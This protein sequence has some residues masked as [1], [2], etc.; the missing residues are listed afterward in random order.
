MATDAADA[1][2]AAI[3]AELNAGQWTQALTAAHEHM[4]NKQAD[5]LD[6]LHVSVV[7][8]DE[9]SEAEDRA[10]GVGLFEIDLIFQKQLGLETEDAGHATAQTG[11]DPDVAALLNLIAAV[12]L[13][14]PFGHRPTVAGL[15]PIQVARRHRPRVHPDLL[16]N[17]RLFLSVLT[18]TY[19]T[20]L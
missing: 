19:R 4:P 11:D 8:P 14:M 5:E 20:R 1:I 3:A 10:E 12:K 17:S 7:A 13:A 15:S 6:T 18:L 9:E 16:L 2:A